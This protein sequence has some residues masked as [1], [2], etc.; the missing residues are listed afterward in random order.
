MSDALKKQDEFLTLA[1]VHEAFISW[2]SE[3]QVIE[4]GKALLM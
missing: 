1:E 2:E 3:K 4:F